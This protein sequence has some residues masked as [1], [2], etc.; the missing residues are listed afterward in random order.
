MRPCQLSKADFSLFSRDSDPCEAKDERNRTI[1]RPLA[2]RGD[3]FL[4]LKVGSQPQGQL[5]AGRS[6]E[7]RGG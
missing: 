3:D 1:K 4:D 2:G 7:G 6:A 5:R